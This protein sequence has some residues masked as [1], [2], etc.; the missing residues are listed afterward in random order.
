MAEKL[1]YRRE[2]PLYRLVS[3]GL[4]TRVYDHEGRE[5]QGVRSVKWE[6]GYDQLGTLHVE[7]IG[8]AC[9]GPEMTEAL[10]QEATEERRRTIQA[11]SQSLDDAPEKD[12]TATGRA[13]GLT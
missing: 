10:T 2:K 11:L 1:R 4:N 3:D 13:W 5:L 8:A 7:L 12:V 6:G 9:G